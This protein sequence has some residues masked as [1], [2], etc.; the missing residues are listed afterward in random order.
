MECVSGMLFHE[1]IVVVAAF[2]NKS[3]LAGM[4]QHH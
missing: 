3:L 2:D 1:V 4:F